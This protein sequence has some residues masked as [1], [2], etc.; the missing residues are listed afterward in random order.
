VV[1]SDFPVGSFKPDAAIYNN[2]LSEISANEHLHVAGSSVDAWG[3]RK[4]GMFS[5]LLRSSVYPEQPYPC[6]LLKDVKD[7]P[8]LLGL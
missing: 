6:F 7:L 2:V 5:A 8:T 4:A 3:A 1:G